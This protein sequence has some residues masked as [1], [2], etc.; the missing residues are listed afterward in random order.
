MIRSHVFESSHEAYDSQAGAIRDG[1]VI[2]VPSEH[3]VAVLVGVWPVHVGDTADPGAFRLLAT[4]ATWRDLDGGKY[5]N[6]AVVAVTLLTVE[7]MKT[8]GL[9]TSGPLLDIA[10]AHGWAGEIPAQERFAERDDS[11]GAG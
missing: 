7:S 9:G 8:A 1:D 10:R 3:R 6:S 11:Q 4:N 2:L 5:L